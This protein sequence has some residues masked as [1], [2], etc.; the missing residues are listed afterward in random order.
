MS[1]KITPESL[2]KI[3]E[4]YPKPRGYQIKITMMSPNVLEQYY[5]ALL[6]T[7]KASN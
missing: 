1:K 7:K 3:V 2:A 6:R 4:N 5:K